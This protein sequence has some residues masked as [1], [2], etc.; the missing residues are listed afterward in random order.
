VETDAGLIIPI[1]VIP[2]AFPQREAQIL[3]R[4]V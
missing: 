4:Y 1:D 3:K 2:K